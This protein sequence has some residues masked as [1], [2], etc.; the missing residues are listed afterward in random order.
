MNEMMQFLEATFGLMV[1]IF[2]VSNL[3]TMGLQVN[4]EGVIRVL[5]NKRA[6]LLIFV[7]G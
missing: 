4:V 1:L 2:T 5:K 7:W 3:G 6:L